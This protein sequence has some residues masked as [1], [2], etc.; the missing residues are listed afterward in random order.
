MAEGNKSYKGLALPLN[1]EYEQ[2][3]LTAATDMVTLTGASGQTG[4]FIVCQDSSGNEKFVVDSDGV[5]VVPSG[6]AIRFG[7]FLTTAPT[8]GL[9]AGDIFLVKASSTPQIAIC[10]DT[11]SNTLMYIS[12]NTSTF[13]RA[14]GT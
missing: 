4:D 12:A 14:S 5:M 1:G 6:S 3:Q 10:T 2:T 8:T 11:T 7:G 9:T 13:G